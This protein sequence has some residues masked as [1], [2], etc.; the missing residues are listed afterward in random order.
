MQQ[1]KLS[2]DE[3]AAYYKQVHR[4]SLAQSPDDE[5]DPVMRPG[6][7]RWAN[8]F[9]DYAHRLGMKKA[10]AY[11]ESQWGSLSNRSVLDLGCGRGRWVREYSSRGAQVTGVDISPEAIEL[12]AKEIPQHRFLCQDIARLT[13]PASTFDVVNS[14]TVLQ[15]LPEKAQRT[16]LPLI[17]KS[18]KPGGYLV[19]LENLVDY[20]VHVY[21]HPMS[22]W[23]DMVRA[24]GLKLSWS[25][26][27]NF[28]VLL[29]GLSSLANTFR[30][31]L[32]VSM[33]EGSPDEFPDRR[34][35]MHQVRSAVEAPFALASFPLEWT[36]HRVPL[37]RPSHGVMVFRK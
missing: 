12:I 9:R 10:F 30:R 21:S 32:N 34:S 19:L 23:V 16:L 4:Y 17:E 25:A 3:M 11:L 27:S 8:R 35:F 33:A 20:S 2:P 36:L 24:T 1:K 13:V 28:E 14:V 6:G 15:H 29:R 18:L 31:Q 22:E 7:T 26:G 37:A 5:L